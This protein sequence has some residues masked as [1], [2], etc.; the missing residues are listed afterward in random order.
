MSYLSRDRSSDD[1]PP[2]LTID[3][4]HC[5]LVNTGIPAIRSL[6]VLPTAIIRLAKT[7]ISFLVE[8]FSKDDLLQGSTSEGHQPA[9]SFTIPQYSMCSAEE[10]CTDKR[11]CDPLA[12]HVHTPEMSYGLP[13][14]AQSLLIQPNLFRRLFSEDVLLYKTP[15]ILLAFQS[16]HIVWF[17]L[18]ATLETGQGGKQHWQLLADILDVPISIH[19]V[20]ITTQGAGEESSNVETLMI[21]GKTGRTLF[22]T[23]L[24]HSPQDSQALTGPVLCT[25]QSENK[26]FYST[27]KEI[28]CVHLDKEKVKGQLAVTSWR[29]RGVVFM[30]AI[31]QSGTVLCS[32]LN[33]FKIEK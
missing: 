5:I 9:Y 16:G 6:I 18:K 26:L 13:G 24:D 10:A 22:M 19:V 1:S 17:P 4:N 20:N 28:I 11:S 25:L 27:G 30:S 29:F 33:Y 2:V 7:D 12:Y 32:F 31:S 23:A 8:V 15:V 14:D 21:L 3:D